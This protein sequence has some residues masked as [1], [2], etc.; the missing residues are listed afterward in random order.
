MRVRSSLRVEEQFK[1]RHACEEQ[2]KGRHACLVCGTQ[3]SFNIQPCCL[4]LKIRAALAFG[5]VYSG[6]FSLDMPLEAIGEEWR[7]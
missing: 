4:I 3:V 1:G 6:G 5:L 7:L 2:F